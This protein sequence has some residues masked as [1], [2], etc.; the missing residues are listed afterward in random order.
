MED[1]HIIT[2]VKRQRTSSS[3]SISEQLNRQGVE[4]SSAT[5]RHQLNEQGLYKLNPLTKPLLSDTH[6][7]N[8]V[9]WA[10]TY[11]KSNWK[12]VVFTDET[13]FPQFGKPK[14][15]WRQKGEII[16]VPTVKHP[17]KVHAYGCFSE[18]GFR[19]I[20]CFTSNLN[21]DLLCTIYKTTLLPSA[22]TFFGEDNNKWIL[23]E[24]NDPKHKS[25]KA[26]GMPCW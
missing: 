18:K 25:K 5:I 15:V 2:M 13:T 10:K 3:I 6:M 4:L 11:K 8:R 19:N 12:N 20:Y 7:K 17:A 1:T 16:K 21:A 24:D 22:K 26:R 23:Q 14:K 9:K